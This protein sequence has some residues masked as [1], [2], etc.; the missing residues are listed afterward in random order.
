M[1]LSSENKYQDILRRAIGTALIVFFLAL[2]LVGLKL[3]ESE[4]GL[5]LLTRMDWVFWLTAIAFTLATLGGFF[6]IR[7]KTE[8]GGAPKF[9]YVTGWIYRH[10]KIISIAALVF[11]AMW[12]LSPWADRYGIDLATSILIYIMLGWGLNIVV[13]LSGLLD[14]GYV[15]FYAVGGYTYAL[16]AEY[17]GLSF[18]QCIPLSA[19]IALLFSLLVGTPVLRLRGDYLA[20]VTLG[21]GEILRIILIN[22]QDFTHGPNGVT[23]IPRPSFFGIP[24]AREAENGQATFHQLFGLEFSTEHRIIFLYYVIFA[25]A[26]ITNFLVLR[27]RRLPI[28]RA[29]E[30]IKEDEIASRAVGINPAS[31]KLSAY[32]IGAMLAGTAGAFFAARQGFISPESFTFNETALIVAIVVLAGAGSQLGVVLAALI[33]VGLPELGREFADF[34]MLFFGAVMIGIMILRPRG[35]FADR[36]PSILSPMESRRG[37]A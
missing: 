14:L 20:I 30:A 5:V 36:V 33:L 19:F 22:W 24:F 18:W 28:G 8:F 9:K 11:A 15:A 16:A 27:L 37:R 13:G 2:P 17:W 29:W 32:A 35:I 26:L 31:V 34:R 25:L 23:S 6:G 12:P 1:P 7:K 4:N 10:S 21:F 3:D